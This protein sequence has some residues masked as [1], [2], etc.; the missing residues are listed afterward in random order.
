MGDAHNLQPAASTPFLSLD[1]LRAPFTSKAQKGEEARRSERRKGE[2][3]LSKSKAQ[4]KSTAGE[5]ALNSKT[6]DDTSSV[7]ALQI[8]RLGLQLLLR[9]EAL[10]AI[11]P[12]HILWIIRLAGMVVEDSIVK[13]SSVVS[14]H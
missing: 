10:S 2:P 3:T 9:G 5:A 6:A 13:V 14:L 4:K 8:P 1:R 7:S 11:V 12:L